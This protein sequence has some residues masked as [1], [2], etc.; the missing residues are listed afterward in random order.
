L[1]VAGRRLLIVLGRRSILL[2]LALIHAGAHE[3]TGTGTRGTADGN[4]F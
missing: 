1:I 4:S 3:R 2:A